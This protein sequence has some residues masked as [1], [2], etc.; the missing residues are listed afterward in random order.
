MPPG[1]NDATEHLPDPRKLE[2]TASEPIPVILVTGFLGSGKTTLIRRLL[3]DSRLRDTAVIVNEFGEVGFDHE[4]METAEEDTI[5]LSGGCLCCASRG[6]LVRALYSLLDRR[7]RREL[8]HYRRVIIET[9]GLADPVPLLQTFLV[10]PMRL[11]IYR[12]QGL[13]TLVDAVSGECT[14]AGH[15]LA[16]RQVALADRIFM[17]KADMLDEVLVESRLETLRRYTGRQIAPVPAGETLAEVMTASGQQDVTVDALPHHLHA[18]HDY[19][20]VK[21][22]FPYPIPYEMITDWLSATVADDGDDILRIKG[23][24][25]TDGNGAVSVDAVQHQWHL[26]RRLER[27]GQTEGCLV[28]VTPAGSDAGGR[29]LQRLRNLCG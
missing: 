25:R 1:L 5:L 3:A 16:R 15:E 4:L 17:S 20:S 14:L 27:T 18:A 7:E 26:P 10:D 11:S 22:R 6:D 23:V 28:V 8:P 24:L 19:E 2:L 12:L 29:A 9:S 21:A 13:I